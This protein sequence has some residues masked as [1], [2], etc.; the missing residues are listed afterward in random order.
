MN[1]DQKNAIYAYV[2]NKCKIYDE[3]FHNKSQFWDVHILPVITLAKTISKEFKN[4]DDEVV[5]FAA[6]FHDIACVENYADNYDNHHEI[7]AE[8]AAK[9]I[10]DA[11]PIEKVL[12]IQECIRTHRGSVK[13]LNKSNE[14]IIVADADAI[15]HFQT[16]GYIL[17]WRIAYGDQKYDAIK[18]TVCKI[19]KSYNKMSPQNQKKYIELYQSAKLQLLQQ[20]FTFQKGFVSSIINDTQCSPLVECGCD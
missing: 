4:V 11:L 5:E 18:Y 14:A 19:D 12:A 17:E 20:G 6:L 8:I 7:G 10:G 3:Q 16:I 2:K 15:V 13:S 9:I 1:K